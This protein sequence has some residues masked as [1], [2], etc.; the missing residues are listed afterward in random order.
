[1]TRG[2]VLAAIL[3]VLSGTVSLG[4]VRVVRHGDDRLA[5]ITQVDVVVEIAGDLSGQCAMGRA[6]V[7]EL[8]QAALREAGV[9][10]S[11]SEKAS[12][13]FYSVV[14]R[15]TTAAASPASSQPPVRGSVCVAFVETELVAQVAGFPEGDRNATGKWGS[16]LIGQM[17]LVAK[18]DLVT[19]APEEHDAAV[20]QAVRASVT[21]IATK[22]RA[23]N[24]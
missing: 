10:A 23:A 18:T 16:I 14:I 4:Q 19:G 12:S 5:G 9:K 2:F 13:W 21:L 1:M 20:R 15:V 22:L 24:P 6:A 17:P 8:A 3:G 7:A 11:L